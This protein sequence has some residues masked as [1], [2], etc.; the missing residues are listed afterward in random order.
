MN[1]RENISDIFTTSGAKMVMFG[2]REVPEKRLCFYLNQ[3]GFILC[4]MVFLP[5]QPQL[6]RV[7]SMLSNMAQHSV[8]VVLCWT[9]TS[10]HFCL[11]MLKHVFIFKLSSSA[12][13]ADKNLLIKSQMFLVIDSSLLNQL[14]ERHLKP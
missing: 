13:E 3:R 4:T 14:E 12:A 9:L 7:G 11:S 8:E 1:N 6:A 10:A 2:L 5:Y